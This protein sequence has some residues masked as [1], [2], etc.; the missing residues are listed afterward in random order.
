MVN[1]GFDNPVSGL[2]FSGDL[3]N[4]LFASRKPH[5]P[6]ADFS[7]LRPAQGGIP[8]PPH[9][10]PSR[11]P[12]L[13]EDDGKR[14]KPSPPMT[15]P[16]HGL[17]FADPAMIGAFLDWLEG[18]GY[19]GGPG[20]KPLRRNRPSKPVD[21][22]LEGCDEGFD[23]GGGVVKGERRTTARGQ[24]EAAMQRLRAVVAAANRHALEIEQ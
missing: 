24:A 19:R 22:A 4:S 13:G 21:H 8:A 6:A 10:I 11:L 2:R 14:G 23:L 1:C 20:R 18:L 9:G 7:D 12:A 15:V 17:P 3:G 16:Q 5:Q